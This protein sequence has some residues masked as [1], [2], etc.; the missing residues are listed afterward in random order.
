M[1]QH[2]ALTF[3]FLI[4]CCFIAL[5]KA[6]AQEVSLSVSPPV[7]EILLAPNKKVVQT[8]TIK[9]QGQAV[10]IIPSLHTATP[11]DEDGHVKVDPNPLSPVS[12]PLVITLS[13]YRFGDA[14]SLDAGASLSLTLTLEGASTDIAIDSYLALVIQASPLD[15]A[16]AATATTP[17]IAP[18]LLVTLTPS[19]VI[20]ANVEI[21]AFNLPFLHDTSRPFTFTPIIENK[22][23]IMIRPSLQLNIIGPGGR[24]EY[25]SEPI[26][27]LILK[28]GERAFGPLTWSPSWSN[29]GPHRVRLTVLTEGGTKLTEVEKVVWFL[30]LRALLL[31]SVLVLV[32]TIL[33]LRQ[34]RRMITSLLVLLALTLTIPAGRVHASLINVSDTLSTS[35]L[36][37]LARPVKPQHLIQFTPS[38]TTANGSFRILLPADQGNANDGVADDEGYDFNTQVDVAVTSVP[39]FTFGLPQAIASGSPGCSVPINYHCFILRYTGSGT[40]GRPI[41]LTLG[42]KD[43]SHTLLAPTSSTSHT[44]GNADIYGFAIRHYNQ[45]NELVEYT[46]GNIG[47]VEGVSVVATVKGTPQPGFI[48][49][50]SL[51]FLPATVA[52]LITGYGIALILI[53]LLAIGLLWLLIFL[54]RRRW[55]LLLLDI[56]GDPIK[57]AKV[58]HSIP[59]TRLPKSK[60]LITRKD[61]ILFH[62]YKED[63]GRLYIKH[64]SRYST[65]TIRLEERTYLLSLSVKRS[66]YTLILD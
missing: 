36:S 40:A 55:N 47:H 13:P 52:R 60:V 46:V 3:G 33:V 48:N 18:L 25:H 8:F 28:D 65:L 20:P 30:P 62:L 45:N 39:G 22:A 9:N 50:I 53:T 6:H 26:K 10:E 43:G 23:D 19:G 61:P 12:I 38:I 11:I 58:Y 44:P 2:A 34:R 56:H 51:P 57:T 16:R 24:E 49:V 29:L 35:E 5:P 37:T 4:L 64:L 27:N 41:T 21:K 7:V 66:R 63:K 42:N 31:L 32:L 54:W 14:I 17:A 1:K 15:L 59:D